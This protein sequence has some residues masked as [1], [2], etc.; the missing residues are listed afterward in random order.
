MDIIINKALDK[1]FNTLTKS[2]Y[3]EYET[4]FTI[5]VLIF[6]DEMINGDCKIPITE[7]DYNKINKALYCIYGSNCFVPYP[8][9]SISDNIY[10]NK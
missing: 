2:G 7:D 10:C 4:V 6:I 9:T 1:Y 3:V 5:L 8:D